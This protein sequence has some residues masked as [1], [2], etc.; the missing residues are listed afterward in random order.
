M[1]EPAGPESPILGVMSIFTHV[2]DQHIGELLEPLGL[3]LDQARPA[4]HGI[5]NSNYL[6]YCH[7]ADGA[8]RGLVL[9]LFESRPHAELPW[10]ADL[11]GNLAAAGLPVPAPLAVHGEHILKI[12]GKPAFLVP[13]LPGEH[14]FNPDADHC[15]AVG[16]LLAQLH[17]QPLPAT[18]APHSERQLLTDLATELP[19][20]DQDLAGA[21]RTT[22][23]AWADTTGTPCLIHADLFR[24]N[25][26]FS[27]HSVTGLL[28]LYNACA[29]LPEYDL[30]VALNDWCLND[31]GLPRP[32]CTRALLDAYRQHHPLNEALLPLA[33]AVA[34]LRFYLSRCRAQ[35]LAYHR[36][37]AQGMVSKDPEPM[38]RL[39]MLRWQAWQDSLAFP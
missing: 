24:D 9:T 21:A 33:L 6:L 26:L 25:V 14:V 8:T 17:A 29:E 30:A 35:R 34:A 3:H 1:K 28:D 18:P 19:A 11:L 20:D 13:W 15:A 32:D 36:D 12:A 39:F 7:G 27:G 38:R 31:T 4:T 10:F 5:E 23:G 16:A 2:S 37:Q 22:L